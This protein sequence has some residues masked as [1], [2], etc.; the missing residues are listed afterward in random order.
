V[1]VANT[2][3][4][5]L[6]RH[7]PSAQ[8]TTDLEYCNWAFTAAFT[9]EAVLK[10]V[11]YGFVGYIKKAWN[12]LDFFIVAVSIAGIFGNIGGGA[13]VFRVLRVLRVLKIVQYAGGVLRLFRT[14]LLSAPALL[15]VG[16]LILL[17][18][19]CFAVLGVQ[20]F[21]KVRHQQG[22]TDLANFD[23]FGNAML[24]LFP[25][26][27]GDWSALMAA[28]M[29]QPPDCDEAADDCGTAFA[30]VYFQ[31][32][33]AISNFVLLNTLIAA[34]L[35]NYKTDIPADE[36]TARDVRRFTALWNVRT[37]G[38][39]KMHVIDLP[40][41]VQELPAPLGLGKP[42]GAMHLM[43]F[44]GELEVRQE[45][46]RIAFQDLLRALTRRAL[47]ID[48]EMLKGMEGGL[49][50]FMGDGKNEE[51]REGLQREMFW[52]HHYEHILKRAILRWVKRRRELKKKKGGLFR[53]K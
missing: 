26:F 21:G 36:V 45:G 43:R 14:L 53:L 32:F 19:F 4:L 17:L 18:F 34:V 37:S 48:S 2:V 39:P 41:F 10:I 52:V 38:K 8:W 1:I 46:G 27:T 29:V 15:N 3:V 49:A 11:A 6:E 25:A 30:P 44:I 24:L 9:V 47:R 13:S 42:V 20:L 31:S 22:L 40:R 23:N 35:E 12:T 16:S 7:G 28:C 51:D 5:A 50:D 33:I